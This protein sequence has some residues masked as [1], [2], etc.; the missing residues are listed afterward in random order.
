MIDEY[1]NKIP[2]LTILFLWPTRTQIISIKQLNRSF[3]SNMVTEDLPH[4][5]P[6]LNK[7]EMNNNNINSQKARTLCAVNRSSG[8]TKSLP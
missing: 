1:Y 5:L 7:N 4:P 3:Q 2:K 8:S 6:M